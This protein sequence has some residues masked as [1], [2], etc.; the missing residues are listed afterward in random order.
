MNCQRPGTAAPCRCADET[1]LHQHG[2]TPPASTAQLAASTA[3]GEADST[4]SGGAAQSTP[5]VQ[6]CRSQPAAHGRRLRGGTHPRVVCRQAQRCPGGEVA[7]SGSG[8]LM[9]GLLS[10]RSRSRSR[11]PAAAYRLARQAAHGRRQRLEHASIASVWPQHQVASGWLHP[12][13]DSSSSSLSDR[14]RSPGA[15]ASTRAAA[16]PAWRPKQGHC[17]GDATPR[18]ATPRREGFAARAPR[19]DGCSSPH[20]CRAPADVARPG[21]SAA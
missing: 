15:A 16:A 17:R 3:H 14:V 10:R 12:R 5:A 8:A 4:A 1:A 13:P 7:C 2:R 19:R 9:I 6:R 18:S 20:A 21:G 11:T